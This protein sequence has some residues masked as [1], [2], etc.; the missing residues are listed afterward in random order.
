[1]NGVILNRNNNHAANSVLKYSNNLILILSLLLLSLSLSGGDLLAQDYG[2]TVLTTEATYNHRSIFFIDE[3]MGWIVGQSGLILKTI[4]SGENWTLQNGGTLNNLLSVYFIDDNTGWIV[5]E[6]GT[7]LKTTDSGENWTTQ[8]GG[9]QFA[10]HTLA[11]VFFVDE[12]TGWAGG[13]SETQSIIQTTDGGNNWSP[14]TV[15]SLDVLSLFFIDANIGWV[16]GGGGTAYKT[17]DGGENWIS[18]WDSLV[19]G[20]NLTDVFFINS[21]IGWV[22][23]ALSSGPMW[24]TTD[25]GN[26]WVEQVHPSGST[27]SVHFTSADT[28]WVVGEDRIFTTTDGGENWERQEFGGYW[29]SLY[30]TDA[31]HGWAIHNNTFQNF[32]VGTYMK[33]GLLDVFIELTSPNGGERFR[34]GSVQ[35]IN[36]TSVSI[37]NIRIEYTADEGHTWITIVEN[38]EGSIGTYSWTVPEL[39]SLNNKIRIVDITNDNNFDISNS[40]FTIFTNVPFTRY[41]LY[42]DVIAN[43]SNPYNFVAPDR[44]VRF[45]IMA[46]NNIGQNLLTLKGTI[47]SNNPYVTITDS[48]G[49]FNNILVGQEGWADDPYEF[50]ISAS[51]PNNT[52]ISFV[53]K[54]TDEIVTGGPWFSQ[55]SIPVIIKPFIISRVLMDDDNNPDSDGNDND[56]AEPGEIIE[57]IPLLDNVSGHSFFTVS[58]LLTTPIAELNIWN[59][60]SGASGT[61]SNT[62]RYNVIANSHLVVDSGL[63][64]VV[65]EEDFVFDYNLANTNQLWFEMIMSGYADVASGDGG[66]LMKWSTDFQLNLDFPPIVGVEDEKNSIPYKYTLEQN[67][68]NPFN[69]VTQIKYA[70]PTQGN[71]SLIIYDLRG[72]QV[73]RLINGNI[74]AGTHHVMWDASNFPSGI[75]FYRLQADDFVQTRK[76][77]LL[78]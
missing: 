45:K 32:F 50:S 30:F 69:P 72:R 47:T 2:W 24:K 10:T 71:V 8:D 27:L 26:T 57:I 56:I 49:S 65:P 41:D 63:T 22:V 64:N 48:I 21:D 35:N 54:I 18:F 73:G 4:D 61:V 15:L 46:E 58:G 60:V 36:W 53:L 17:I 13:V 12:S 77:V 78:K 14:S 70:L 19:G 1:M 11:A 39:S 44:I 59:G 37:N 55:F 51:V 33:Y 34:V 67:Y 25:G 42:Q 3:N 52:N 62:Y 9:T 28:G 7:I 5:G 74:A 23:T 43:S 68:P 75:Y 40:T 76:M 38:I 6:N 66:V 29:E 20:I 31:N 16:V